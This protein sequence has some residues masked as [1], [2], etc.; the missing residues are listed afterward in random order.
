MGLTG[1]RRVPAAVNDNSF[2]PH[3]RRLADRRT[4]HHSGPKYH[5]TFFHKSLSKFTAKEFPARARNDSLI[6]MVVQ[7]GRSGK[8]RCELPLLLSYFPFLIY[9]SMNGF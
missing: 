3:L 1:A 5:Q 4:L 6:S 9:Y 2:Q 8:P 7:R